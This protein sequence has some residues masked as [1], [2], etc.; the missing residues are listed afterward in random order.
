MTVVVK[1]GSSIVADERGLVRDDVLDAVCP[2]VVELHRGG[3]DVCLITSGA[4]A[5]GMR[6]M[7]MA[8]RPRE[9]ADMQAASAVGQGSLFRA[10]ESRLAAGDVHAAQVLLTSVDIS[11]RMHYLNARHALRRL[12]DWRCVPVINE[13]DTTATDEITFGDNDFLSAQV[14]MLLGARLLVLLTDQA[15]VH[16]ADPRLDP[17]AE[18]I[19]EVADPTELRQHAIGGRS[20]TFGSGGMRSKVAAAEM[21]CAAGVPA[22]I[23]DGQRPDTLRRAVAGE[24]VGTRFAAH[25]E[26]TSAF[27]LWLRYAKPSRGRVLVDDGAARVLRERGSSL[28]PVGIVGVEGEFAPGDAVDVVAGG[29]LVGKGIVNYSA[30]ELGRLSGLKSSEVG[31]LLPGGAEEAVHR[32]R[33]VLA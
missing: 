9:V 33:F 24:R 27:K 29:D 18:L 23:C 1:L 31:Q 3:E 17:T 14:S 32:D 5:L 6:I 20:S 13:N 10:Y 2:Q 28:L 25:P 21:A 8:T 19:E 11:A 16:T 30:T 7:G 26:P 4:I 22:V 15:G 12:L